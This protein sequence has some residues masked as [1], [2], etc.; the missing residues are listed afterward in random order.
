VLLEERAQH[1]ANVLFVIDDQD[2][3]HAVRILGEDTP[4]PP[5]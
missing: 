4:E 5:S 3:A 2:A 1:E